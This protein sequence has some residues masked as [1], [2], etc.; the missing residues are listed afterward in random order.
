MVHT[1]KG[2]VAEKGFIN[3]LK[4]YAN[5]YDKEYSESQGIEEDECIT[6]YTPFGTRI[7]YKL[8]EFDELLDSSNLTLVHQI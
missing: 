6:P 5:L 2:Y 7:L 3:R 1:P 4:Q 8:V